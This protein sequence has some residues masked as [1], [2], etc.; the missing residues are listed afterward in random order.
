MGRTPLNP[1]PR[2]IHRM[3]LWPRGRRNLGPFQDVSPTEDWTPSQTGTQRKPSHSTPGGRH[4]PRQPNNSPP[5][6]SRRRCSRRSAGDSSPLQSTPCCAPTRKTLRPRRRTC[7]RRPLPRQQSSSRTHPRIPAA[8]SHPTPNG[9]SPPPE[10]PVLPTVR[11]YPTT[12]H[13]TPDRH[14]AY[15]PSTRH[16]TGT[17][18]RSTTG[19]THTPMSMG[20]PQVPV[21]PRHRPSTGTA[22][23]QPPH[24]P[25]ACA[26]G[27]HR[28]PCPA[29]QTTGSA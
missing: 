4:G 28:R 19:T 10:T 15:T 13:P 2:T 25:S 24:A 1:R 21:P 20:A 12:Y 16:N 27:Y 3:H 14:H 7:N 29:T 23:R 11:F 22:N 26:S 9:P 6:S 18:Q 8:C 5:F 17:A